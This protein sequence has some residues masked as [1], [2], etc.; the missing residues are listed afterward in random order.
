M[1][2]IVNLRQVRKAKARA[3]KSAEADTNRARHG[4]TLAERDRDRLV[5]EQA[6]RTLDNAKHDPA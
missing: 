5:E 2:E 3:E 6:R 4:R 1:G